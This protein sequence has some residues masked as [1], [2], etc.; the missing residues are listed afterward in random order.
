MTLEDALEEIL[1]NVFMLKVS[2]LNVFKYLKENLLWSSKFVDKYFIFQHNGIW[3]VISRFGDGEIWMLN[4]DFFLFA[5]CLDFIII[6]I[7]G[8]FIFSQ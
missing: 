6:I 7:I 5:M 3:H 8:Q 2:L 1:N 4:V